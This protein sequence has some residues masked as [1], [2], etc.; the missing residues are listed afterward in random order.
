MKVLG[1]KQQCTEEN[2]KNR[3]FLNT[4]HGKPAAHGLIRWF[5]RSNPF[6]FSGSKSTGHGLR[7]CG[8]AETFGERGGGGR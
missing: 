6:L 4:P 5:F 3:V 7:K 2:N 8:G 1:K